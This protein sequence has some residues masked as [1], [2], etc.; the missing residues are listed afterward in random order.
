MDH[1]Q[2]ERRG[3]AVGIVE[4]RGDGGTLGIHGHAGL[5]A[6]HLL[7][8]PDDPPFQIPTDVA[9]G[10]PV[11]TVRM[12]ALVT[13]RSSITGEGYASIEGRKGPRSAEFSSMTGSTL[14]P[15]APWVPGHRAGPP[16][17]DPAPTPDS[18]TMAS[19]H[20]RWGQ[21]SGFDPLI[22]E[23]NGAGVTSS[24]RRI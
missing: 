4:P 12:R 7:V 24:G 10:R 3:V 14:C 8:E 2:A 22:V 9:S 18:G 20:G 15:G 16:G 5:D 13:S 6:R 1:A 23:T 11:S 21:R 17:W 19:A